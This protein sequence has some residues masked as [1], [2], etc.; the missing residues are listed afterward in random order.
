MCAELVRPVFAAIVVMVVVMMV[1]K[2]A[3]GETVGVI[4]IRQFSTSTAADVK[5][6]LEELTPKVGRLVLDLRGN[7][8]GYFPGGVDVARQLL[9]NDATITVVTDYKLN[10]VKYTTFDDGVELE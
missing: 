1:V 4:R 5:K 10:E 2:A 9:P 6:A 7:T 3:K 8:G